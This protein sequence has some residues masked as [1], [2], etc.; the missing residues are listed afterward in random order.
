[1]RIKNLL[2][3]YEYEAELSTSHSASSYGLPVLVDLSNGEAVD[4]FSFAC[5][6][7]IEATEQEKDALRKAGYLN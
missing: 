7:V 3:D 2:N 5:S 6:E 4:K 1:M